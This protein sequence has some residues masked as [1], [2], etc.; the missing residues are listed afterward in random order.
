MVLDVR[1]SCC[2]EV[3]GVVAGLQCDD[4]IRICLGCVGWLREKLAAIDVTPILPVLD[5]AVAAAFYDAAVS[6]VH[7]PLGIFPHVNPGEL[8]VWAGIAKGLTG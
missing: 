6:F 2:G 1:C 5:M 8:F 3:R 7:P 4:E